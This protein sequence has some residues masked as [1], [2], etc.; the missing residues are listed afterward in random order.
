M[1]CSSLRGGSPA[2]IN[3]I[4]IIIYI[5]MSLVIFTMS[6]TS[7]VAPSR[8]PTME[9]VGK[10]LCMD[11]IMTLLAMHDYQIMSGFDARRYRCKLL[12]VTGPAPSGHVACKGFMKHQHLRL[13]GHS[14][15]LQRLVTCNAEDQQEQQRIAP[16][17]AKNFLSMMSF[18]GNLNI[19][20]RLHCQRQLSEACN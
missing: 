3:V 7:L 10:L 6:D 16:P 14:K 5:K 9:E 8:W 4:S 18:V 12:P 19:Y 20:R 15:S 13:C 2:A 17:Q 11:Y 1:S